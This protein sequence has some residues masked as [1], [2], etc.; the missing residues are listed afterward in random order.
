[1]HAGYS[2]PT[3]GLKH[4]KEQELLPVSNLFLRKKVKLLYLKRV[5]GFL[6]YY[7]KGI[8]DCRSI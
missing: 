6:L 7:D 3:P 1:M 2:S 4:P 5:S 8:K